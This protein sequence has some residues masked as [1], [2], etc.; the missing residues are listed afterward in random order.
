MLVADDA[1]YH[2]GSLFFPSHIVDDA[3]SIQATFVA[4]YVEVHCTLTCRLIGVEIAFNEESG[5]T[6]KQHTEIAG[7]RF[8][9]VIGC[10]TIVVE[11]DV[12]ANEGAR[13][14]PIHVLV[15][16]AVGPIA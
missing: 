6:V 14:C 11:R 9:I 10:P 2:A 1:I 4:V 3:T 16:I 7:I 13:R 5:H 8:T 15:G 12:A